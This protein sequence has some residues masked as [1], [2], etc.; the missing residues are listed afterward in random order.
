MIGPQDATV[1]VPYAILGSGNW[2]KC[3]PLQF[4]EDALD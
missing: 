4:G 3:S 2:D 1:G